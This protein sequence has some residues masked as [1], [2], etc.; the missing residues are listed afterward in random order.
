MESSPEKKGLNVIVICGVKG[1]FSFLK[2]F[3]TDKVIP[4][5]S[6]INCVLCI[7]ETL[8][9]ETEQLKKFIADSPPLDFPIYFIDCGEAIAPFMHVK[10]DGHYICP[11]RIKFLGRYGILPI[12]PINV[13]FISGV[14]ISGY[15]KEDKNIQGYPDVYTSNSFVKDDVDALIE[16]CRNTPIHIL[17]TCCIPSRLEKKLKLGLEKQETYK[18]LSYKTQRL[19]ETLCPEYVFCNGVNK[20]FSR[21][22]ILNAKGTMTRIIGLIEMNE[23]EKLAGEYTFPMKITAEGNIIDVIRQVAPKALATSF[24]LSNYHMRMAYF[25][26]EKE[27]ISD[28]KKYFAFVS[29]YPITELHFVIR[30][31]EEEHTTKPIPGR[32]NQEESKRSAEKFISELAPDI[33][34]EIDATQ[35]RIT[36]NCIKPESQDYISFFFHKK[37]QELSKVPFIQEIIGI[38]KTNVAAVEKAVNNYILNAYKEMFSQIIDVSSHSN[39]FS[40]MPKAYDVVFGLDMPNPDTVRA[41]KIVVLKSGDDVLPIKLRAEICKALDVNRRLN[42]SEGTIEDHERGYLDEYYRNMINKSK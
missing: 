13:A 35:R 29:R 6:P 38:P 15:V 28:S 36:T 12:G 17:L 24:P 4:Q 1:R 20:P 5:L 14:D 7:G 42:F 22:A 39:I 30:S 9:V 2:T 31:K 8:S 11:D 26:D 19:A 37:G 16:K 23:A 27:S 3:L 32:E 21:A 10:K 25:P 34:N 41:K 40:G 18:L 33:W